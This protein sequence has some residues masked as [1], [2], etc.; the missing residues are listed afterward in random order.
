MS[1]TGWDNKKIKSSRMNPKCVDNYPNK[2]KYFIH[3]T[4]HLERCINHG[5]YKIK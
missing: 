1:Q 3:W 2:I 5:Y 4:R